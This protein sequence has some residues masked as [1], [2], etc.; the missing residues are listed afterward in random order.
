MKPPSCVACPL[1]SFSLLFFYFS[2]FSFCSAFCVPSPITNL[3]DLAFLS[4]RSHLLVSSFSFQPSRRLPPDLRQTLDPQ[5]EEK[6]RALE[7]R[8]W[9]VPTIV[10]LHTLIVFCFVCQCASSSWK[11]R[12]PSDSREVRL[13]WP[14][15]WDRKSTRRDAGTRFPE[16]DLCLSHAGLINA[17]AHGR[18]P[19]KDPK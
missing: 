12:N 18:N 8:L 5:G 7:A 9:L 3:P 11:S 16:P 13:P 14:R 6:K 10:L 19:N 4:L 17:H 1:S 15:A 2:I